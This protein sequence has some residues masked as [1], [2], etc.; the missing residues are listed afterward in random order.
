MVRFYMPLEVALTI[1]DT[2]TIIHYKACNKTMATKPQSQ[3]H[4]MTVNCILHW[5]KPVHTLYQQKLYSYTHT[6]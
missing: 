4:S 2:H 5:G 6:R 1:P 3:F